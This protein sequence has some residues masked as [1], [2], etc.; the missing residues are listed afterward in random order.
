MRYQLEKID[1]PCI[2]N[3]TYSCA[4]IYCTLNK[5]TCDVFDYKGQKM[6]GTKAFTLS[7]NK[8]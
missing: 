5:K 8:F 6:T 7:I 2:G 3:Y 1:C 4:S